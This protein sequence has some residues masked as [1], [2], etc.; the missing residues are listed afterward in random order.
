VAASDLTRFVEVHDDHERA[1]A[2]IRDGRKRTHWMWYLFPQVAGL[3]ESSESRRYAI[4]SLDE[5]RDFLTHPLLGPD[6]L[7]IVDEVWHQVVERDVSV[8]ALFGSP[9]DAKL[10]SSLT[11]FAG[12]A[13]RLGAQTL[14]TFVTHADAILLAASAHGLDRCAVSEAFLRGG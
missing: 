4:A 3:G 11:L 1:L 13:R 10:V 5:A 7:R 14:T 2:E 9:D 8:H 12:V 6:Y